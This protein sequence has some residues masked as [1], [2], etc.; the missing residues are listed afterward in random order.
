MKTT[1]RTTRVAPLA[2]LLALVV[3][4]ATPRAADDFRPVQSPLPVPP[5]PGAIVLFGDG[6]EGEPKFTAMS[7]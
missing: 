2:G 3:V 1:G 6:S 5:P 4:G 7:G